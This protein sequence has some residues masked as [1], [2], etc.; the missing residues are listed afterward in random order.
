MKKLLLLS[1]LAYSLVGYSQFGFKA[2]YASYDLKFNEVGDAYLYDLNGFGIGADY[3]V[4]IGG[5]NVMLGMDFDFIKYK[6]DGYQENHTVITPSAI[7][8]I[9]LG[10][11]FGLRAGL[12]VVNWTSGDDD[13]DFY[14]IDKAMLQLPIGLGINLYDNL[15]FIAQYSIPLGNRVQ[16]GVEWDGGDKITD[17]NFKVGLRYGL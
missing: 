13:V 15:S 2:N 7:A 12:S 17:P 1:A 9:P 16:E 14:G 10:D 8:Q 5:L 11:T 4:E 3:G 6:E